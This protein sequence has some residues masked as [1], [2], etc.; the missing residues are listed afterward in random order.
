[1]RQTALYGT[2]LLFS[3]VAAHAADQQLLNMVMPEAKVLAGVNVLQAK[4][5]PF[6]N[7]VVMQMTNN[8]NGLQ[9]F[10]SS[11]GFNPLQDVNEILAAS[12]GDK[13]SRSGLVL[14]TGTFNADSI[15]AA[16]V[17]DGN[18]QASMYSGATLVTSSNA[19]DFHAVAFLN[20]TIAVAGDVASVKSALDRRNSATPL[21]ADLLTK[22]NTLSTTEDAWSLSLA[23][24]E[25][26]FP[27][28]AAGNQPSP[29]AMIK[30]IQES[31][32]GVKFG[33]EVKVNAQA[34]TTDPKDATALG[35]VIKFVAQLVAMQAAKDPMAASAASLLQNLNVTTSGTAVN[36]A[37]S[38]PENSLE[39]LLQNFH[40]GSGLA[41][42]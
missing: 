8:Q 29:L 27:A 5:S 3:A 23:S 30:N 31:S 32:G 24:F 25:S 39:A 35:D 10:I 11:T 7:Y 33:S 2:I 13:T 6:G 41:H 4:A 18:H 12:S 28:P 37:L 36:I 26:L 9:D 14:A 1:M 17:K 40:H 22:I 21:S 38:I 34:I 15:T 19:K 16:I 42:N 20:N